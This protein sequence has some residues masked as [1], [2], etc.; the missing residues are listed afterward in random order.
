[1]RHFLWVVVFLQVLPM[2]AA[3]AA[4]VSGSDYEMAIVFRSGAVSEYF[5]CSDRANPLSP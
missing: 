5:H 4:R 1:M 3:C 2:P